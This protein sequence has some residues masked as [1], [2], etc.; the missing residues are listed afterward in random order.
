MQLDHGTCWLVASL[1]IKAILRAVGKSLMQVSDSFG[2]H[3]NYL[4]SFS[5]ESFM[6][7][8]SSL[9]RLSHRHFYAMAMHLRR[10]KNKFHGTIT[11]S[12]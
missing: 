1:E 6:R 8:L 12:L 2:L 11:N 9:N 5:S 10:E 4:R 3:E 7:V